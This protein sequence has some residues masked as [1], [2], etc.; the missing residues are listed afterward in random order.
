M[1]N[2]RLLY[3][4]SAQ[5]QLALSR[6]Y[7]LTEG[8]IREGDYLFKLEHVPQKDSLVLEKIA[9]KSK[10]FLKI[11][12][13]NNKSLIIK[14]IPE[15]EFFDFIDK[16]DIESPDLAAFFNKVTK[17]FLKSQKPVWKLES[18]VIDFNDAPLIMGILNVTP[19]SFSDGG[20]F[21]DKNKAIDHAL[22]MIDQGADIIDVG[23]EST[24]PG[25]QQVNTKDELIRV[26]PVIEAI[27][28]YHDVLISID[29]YKS[30]VADAA[31]Q[32]G[33][34][35][36][37]DISG[38]SF[39]DNM[40]AVIEKYR[41]P[42]IIMH[43]RGTPQTMQ[44]D[45]RYNDVQGEVYNFLIKKCEVVAPYNDGRLIIDPGFG[46]AKSI[47]HNLLLLRDLID[48]SFI[49]KPVLVG[50]SRKSFIGRALDIDIDERVVGSI[51]SEI[52]ASLK[53]AGILRVHDVSEI[54]QAKKMLN[55]ILDA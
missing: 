31:I 3:V 4:S 2:A 45:L 41:C 42:Y 52:Y 54:I 53:N 40:L 11:L 1:T 47:Q 46:F 28:K 35:I 51:V 19:D 44:N 39:N 13:K 20:K 34:D 5:R 24:R 33:A 10:P 9:R 30:N 55:R 7:N 6:E 32:A 26:I 15:K 21:F 37:N 48:F 43:I 38:L 49:G 29:S 18:R 23:G 22:K 36:I 17:Y 16:D 12:F 27:R 8:I 25:A 50:V 14:I